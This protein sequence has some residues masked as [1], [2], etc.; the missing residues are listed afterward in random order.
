M[1]Q[2]PES[3]ARLA[4]LHKHL[5][6]ELPPHRAGCRMCVRGLGEL[7]AKRVH[8]GDVLVLEQLMQGGSLKEKP[9]GPLN[10]RDVVPPRT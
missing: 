5:P 4:H 10:K 3:G 7:G 6:H 1:R 8:A 2:A 9:G